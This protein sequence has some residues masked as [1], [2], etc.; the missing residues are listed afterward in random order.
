MEGGG[1]P[2]YGRERLEQLV[3]DLV[4]AGRGPV[5]EVVGGDGMGRSATLRMLFERH[6]GRIPAA[7]VDA[8]RCGV[9]GRRAPDDGGRP[10]SRLLLKAAAQL[11]EPRPGFGR[12][13]FHRLML[14]QTALGGH[15]DPEAHPDAMRQ[16]IENYRQPGP[17]TAQ[18]MNLIAN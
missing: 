2:Y 14:G 17:R 15:L 3:V 18:I 8:G 6:G 7:L 1:M 16:L 5:V 12:T 13:P 9:D 4:V 10:V 11:R